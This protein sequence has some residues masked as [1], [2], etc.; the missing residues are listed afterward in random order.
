LQDKKSTI[1]KAT[2]EARAAEMLGQAMQTSPAFLELRRLE[3]ARDIATVMSKSRNRVYLQS[4]SLL[5][6]IAQ[7]IDL[8][9]TAGD[10]RGYDTVK[11]S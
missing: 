3:A 7:P 11:K 6:N 5:M 10:L 9:S 1:I 8:T 4:D 2:G